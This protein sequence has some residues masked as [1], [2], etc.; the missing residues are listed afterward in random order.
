MVKIITNSY[1]M[2]FLFSFVCLRLVKKLIILGN[3]CMKNTE[4]KIG[5]NIHI[6]SK[7]SGLLTGINEIK[8]R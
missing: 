3:T 7:C 4:P 1:I 2:N 8:C 5:I 6:V